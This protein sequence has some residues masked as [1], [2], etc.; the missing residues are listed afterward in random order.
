MFEDTYTLKNLQITT[1][2]EISMDM[3]NSSFKISTKIGLIIW[4]PI[5]DF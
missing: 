2:F 3:N 1:I 4:Q 5:L